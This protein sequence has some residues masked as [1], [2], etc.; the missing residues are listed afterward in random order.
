MSMFRM[1]GAADGDLA[2]D[3]TFA[4]ALK[5]Q[6]GS[7]TPADSSPPEPEPTPPVEPDTKPGGEDEGPSPLPASSPPEPDDDGGWAE[8][9]PVEP[10][11]DPTPEPE[12]P[13]PPAEPEFDLNEL[14]ERHYGER[15]SP[16][17][18]TALLSFVDSVQRLGPDQQA[19]LD[20]ILRGDP[21]TYSQPAPPAYTPNPAGSPPA[22]T[23]DDLTPE[24]RAYLE[25]LYAQQAEINQRLAAQEAEIARRNLEATQA[26]IVQGIQSASNQF[27][28]EFGEVLSP[29]DL[30]LLE[31]R[32]SQSG[33]FPLFM[34]QNG[35]DPARAYRALIDTL[36]YSDPVIRAKVISAPET[37]PSADTPADLARKS[38]ASAVSAG[39]S[40]GRR[41]SPLGTTDNSP[42]SDPA[43]ARQWAI[44]EISRATGMPR[45]S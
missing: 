8:T 33:Q 40:T 17:Q 27:V 12:V 11:V 15:P 24:A 25:P 44:N 1:A 30:V 9:P 28:S 43:A 23:F 20:A 37:T 10:A 6:F 41:V 7:D 4:D 34:Q 13:E 18:M 21:P 29:A 5:S 14:F 42:P 19:A 16:Q 36:V 31:T 3:D 26:Q 32:A 45:I 38:K 22:P 2:T 39:G 35:N